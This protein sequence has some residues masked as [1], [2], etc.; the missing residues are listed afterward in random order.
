MMISTM[1]PTVYSVF[2][3]LL[4]V[5]FHF[6]KVDLI[7][8]KGLVTILLS[9][10]LFTAGHPRLDYSSGATSTA[11]SEGITS[12]S[13]TSSS[14]SSPSLTASG[15]VT[16]VVSPFTM[17]DSYFYLALFVVMLWIAVSGMSVIYVY[18]WKIIKE[19]VRE[20]QQLEEAE[21]EYKTSK[22][23]EWKQELEVASMKL[24]NARV[25][26]EV[27]KKSNK[28]FFLTN[29]E[30]NYRLKKEA[31]AKIE[32]D[33]CFDELSHVHYYVRNQ[34]QAIN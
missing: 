17:T 4:V 9:L 22:Y 32:T 18:H 31:D 14:S 13:S 7:K 25:A 6:Y 21:Q 3:I 24:H 26:Y 28:E 19:Q 27:V 34:I 16:H 10:T 29:E 11:S 1:H 2:F 15:F 30:I 5:L 20:L 12:S 8:S 23:R 33:K